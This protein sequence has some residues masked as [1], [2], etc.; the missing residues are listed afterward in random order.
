MPKVQLNTEVRGADWD[1]TGQRWRIETSQGA[2][3]AKVL[4]S[5]TGPLVEP[6]IP[7][8]PGLESSRPF[9]LSPGTSGAAACEP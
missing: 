7:D 6:K 9:P 8:F 3:T 5:G 1:E 4:V 2:V